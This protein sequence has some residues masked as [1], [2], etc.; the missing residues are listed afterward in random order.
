MQR[1]T[2]ILLFTN[3]RDFIILRVLL[4]SFPPVPFLDKGLVATSLSSI[5]RSLPEDGF[6]RSSLAVVVIPKELNI[7]VPSFALVPDAQTPTRLSIDF[8]SYL[9]ER[10]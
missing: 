1:L 10:K 6:H 8:Q 3:T 2:V 5:Y 4:F 9:P 7:A